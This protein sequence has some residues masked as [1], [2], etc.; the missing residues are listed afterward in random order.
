MIIGPKLIT[1][2]IKISNYFGKKAYEELIKT[3]DDKD[4][5]KAL[6]Y[7]DLAIWIAPKMKI[8][9]EVNTMKKITKAIIK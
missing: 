5:N 8:V 6:R 2:R 1:L 3:T 7:V 9:K 4:L